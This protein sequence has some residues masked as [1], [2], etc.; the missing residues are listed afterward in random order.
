MRRTAFALALS[1]GAT[2]ALAQAP[3]AAT[4][5][6][7]TAIPQAKCEPKPVYPGIKA[8]QDAE[9]AEAFTKVLKAYQDCVKNY[10]AERKAFIEASN[11]AIRTA[12]E[13]HNTVI[14]KFREDQEKA[15][16]ELGQ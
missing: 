7:A 3:A 4:A 12:V 14:N 8:I 16:K 15:K 5:P 10:V 2:A 11:A 13:E 6:A 9:K 1:L